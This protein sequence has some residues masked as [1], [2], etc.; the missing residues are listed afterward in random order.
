MEKYLEALEDKD[1]ILECYRRI[2]GHLERLT[3][4]LLF[5]LI[6]TAVIND[7]A[8]KCQ[9]EYLENN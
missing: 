9:P 4:S 6:S 2:E 7:F 3:V 5:S 1:D 8:A